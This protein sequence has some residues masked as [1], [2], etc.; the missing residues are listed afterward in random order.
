MFGERTDVIDRNAWIDVMR[1]LLLQQS[2]SP[3]RDLYFRESLA[4]S[5]LVKY[6]LLVTG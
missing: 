2:L 3:I 5:L 1:I 6:P 4:Y